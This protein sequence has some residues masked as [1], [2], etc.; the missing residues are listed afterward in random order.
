MSSISLDWW[1]DLQR[2]EI[3][4]LFRYFLRD[5]EIMLGAFNTHIHLHKF[6]FST[7]IISSE[8]KSRPRM[9]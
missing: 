5:T 2:L 9:A 6:A 8:T 4:E 7:R 1:K 3:E